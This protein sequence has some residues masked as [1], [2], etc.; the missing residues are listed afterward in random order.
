ML[1]PK[2][3]STLYLQYFLRYVAPYFNNDVTNDVFSLEPTPELVFSSPPT[4]CTPKQG[5]HIR[6]LFFSLGRHIISSQTVMARHTDFSNLV[7][8]LQ[9][10]TYVIILFV[11]WY[12]G[13]IDMTNTKC[14]IHRATVAVKEPPP[15]TQYCQKKLIK[16]HKG[17]R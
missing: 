12:K 3:I 7:E 10:I 14:A 16:K 8:L 17:I 9:S 1:K 11:S 2:K 15:N 4:V 5:C 13:V 6:H